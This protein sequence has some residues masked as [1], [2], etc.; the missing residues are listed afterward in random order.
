MKTRIIIIIILLAVL[1]GL[2]TKNDKRIMDVLLG[3]I[4]PIKQKYKNF[5]QNIED[6][7][8]S[9]IFQEES[10]EKLSRENRILRK[11]LL[12]QTHYIKQVKDIYDI[13]PQ[14]KRLPAHNISITE[15]ISY[16]KLNSFTQIILTRP[17]E[18][19]EGK[20][21]GLIQG[22]VAAG[23]AVVKNNQL[24]GY[25]TSDNK[26]RF[27][28]FIGRNSAPG[29]AIGLSKNEMI[30]KFIPKWHKIQEGDKVVTSGLDNIFFANV[31]VGI[32]SKV[33]TQSA[34]KVAYIKTYSDVFHPKTFFLIND[35][36]AALA[37]NFDRFLTQIPKEKECIQPADLNLTDVN[38]TL[39]AT[40]RNRTSDSILSEGNLSVPV[41]SSIPA[42]I[43]QTQEEVIE[44]EVPL[45]PH[46]EPKPESEK[47]H[48]IH[49]KK[50]RAT[51]SLDLF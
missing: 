31:P 2:L 30:V 3:T 26:C 35:P 23:V 36:K 33:E 19:H 11:R 27:S 41:I 24:Y 9:Y 49:R 15:T 44:P 43:D 51:Q 4:N 32:V 38:G 6:K 22:T 13:L 12:E 47:K 37:R 45:E 8:Q 29:I 21:Y 16:V 48:I 39:I 18:I 14:L 34:Y 20:L 42:R 50:K 10:I 1:A 7:S 25:L 28:V 40:D 17:K 46:T 5:T